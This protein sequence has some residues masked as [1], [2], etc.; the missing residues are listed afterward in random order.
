MKKIL[1]LVLVLTLIFAI[2]ACGPK[3]EAPAE[4]TPEAEQP[5]ETPETEAEEPAEEPAE[6]AEIDTLKV[7]I[8]PSKD[9]ERLDAQRKP[10]QELLEAELGMPVEVTVGTDYSATIEAMKSGQI[11]VGFLAPT[12]YVLAHDQGAADVIL[13]SMRFDVNDEG[14][15]L[16]DAPLVDS[17]RS[18]LVAG[19]DAGI[20]KVEDLKGKTIAVASYTSTSGFVW[21][22][23]LLADKGLDP[24]S[25]VEWVNSGGHD[26]AIQAVYNGEVD[27]AF[28]FKDAR[29]IIAEE[30]PDVYEKVLFVLDTEPIPNDTISVIPS[31]SQELRDKIADAFLKIAENEE[32]LEVFRSVYEWEGFSKAQD[33]DYDI[34]RTYLKR[35]EEWDF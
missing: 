30:N 2:S 14:E 25:D 5:A 33:S 3:E 16:T 29:Y 13:K 34:V 26:K 35:Q 9:A 28:T 17:F 31:M 32:G 18:Q 19:P 11:H 27:A 21:P 23:N 10:L 4:P 8:I 12:Q 1:A 24:Q 15:K 7:Q 22:A 6:G 20:E